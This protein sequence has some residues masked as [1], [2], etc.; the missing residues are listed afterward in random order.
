MM[1]RILKVAAVQAFGLTENKLHNLELTEHLIDKAAVDSPDVVSLGELSSTSYFC[2]DDSDAPFAW[3]ESVNGPTIQRLAKKAI[4]HRTFV[5]APFFEKTEE[6]YYN[7]AALLDSNGELAGLYRKVHVADINYGNFYTN[8]RRYFSPGN[9]GFPVFDIKG[10]KVGIII[11]Y[12]R[13]FPEAWRSLKLAGAEAVFVP[14]ASAGWRADLWEPELI[15]R[16]V[17]N[18]LFVVAPNRYGPQGS[19]VFFG[20][21]LIIDPLGGVMAKAKED[22]SQ[23]QIITGELDMEVVKESE[24]KL[25]FLKHR[26]PSAYPLITKELQLK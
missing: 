6:A 23:S 25:P 18:N 17:E 12:D 19:S 13:S 4:E 16:A 20:K 24:G 15:V 9:L 21:S 10:V 26:V 22:V 8:E 5:I 2:G 7:S 14:T 1:A 3:A 11:C